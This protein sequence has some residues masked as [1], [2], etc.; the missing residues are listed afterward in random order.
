MTKAPIQTEASNKIPIGLLSRTC[1]VLP[2]RNVCSSRMFRGFGR[3]EY[4]RDKALTSCQVLVKPLM[5]IPEK[6]L[7]M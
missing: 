7:H 6:K 1:A 3:N 2:L 5:P 4:T